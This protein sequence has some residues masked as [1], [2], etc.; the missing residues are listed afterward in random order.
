MIMDATKLEKLAQIRGF[1]TTYEV[2]LELPSGDKFRVGYTNRRSGRGL[3]EMIRLRGRDLLA[4]VGA[5]EDACVKPVPGPAFQFDNG[6]TV[7]F[8]GRTKRD[9]ILGGELP[10][11]PK[12]GE[13]MACTA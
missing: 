4:T 12:V 1:S 13:E 8:S 10:R 6:A 7:R 3:F 11:L 9:A 5:P 2:V